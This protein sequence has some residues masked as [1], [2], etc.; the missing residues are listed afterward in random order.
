MRT[1]NQPVQVQ[2]DAQGRPVKFSF[3]GQRYWVQTIIDF[4][5][6]SGRWWDHEPERQ[7]YR[8]QTTSGGVFELEHLS[9]GRWQLYCIFD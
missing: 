3:Q 6:E 5:R 2:T 7:I 1:V 8:V 9:A 4:W